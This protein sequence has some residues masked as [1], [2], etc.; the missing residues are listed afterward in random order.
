[1][2]AKEFLLEMPFVSDL[3]KG[4][5]SL[6]PDDEDDIG[7]DEQQIMEAAKKIKYAC[8]PFIKNNFNYIN[9]GEYLYRGVKGSDANMD[10]IISGNVRTDRV[11]RDTPRAWHFLLDEFFL[12]QFGWKY[13]SGSIFAT[14]QTN[15]ASDYGAIFVI[16]P[17]GEYKICYSPMI[18][19][20]FT[21]LISDPKSYAIVH[22]LK[23]VVSDKM[24]QQLVSKYDMDDSIYPI[25]NKNDFIDRIGLLFEQAASHGFQPGFKE[26]LI[27][28][29]LPHLKYQETLT[30]SSVG[31]SEAMI[32]CGK[33]YGVKSVGYGSTKRQVQLFKSIM[34]AILY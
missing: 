23:H 19:D 20:A 25:S 22:T 3:N 17:V 1:M 34:E 7:L 5:D 2:R 21:D 27:E 13:R 8:A 33:Y 15:Q 4:F 30:Y 12:R 9:D 10:L 18:T 16:F 31:Q 14:Q 26:F 29:F 6:Q 32:K 11:P 24:V 28:F